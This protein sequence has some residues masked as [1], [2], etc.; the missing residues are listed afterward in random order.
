MAYRILALA[1]VLLI[2]VSGAVSQL[3]SSRVETGINHP[4]S[5]ILTS[6]NST[7]TVEF[8]L[9]N[10]VAQEKELRINL[11]GVNAVFWSNNQSGMYYTLPGNTEKTFQIAVSP[12][13][14]GE[15]NLTVVTY[16]RDLGTENVDR[17]PVA[18][19]ESF[20]ASVDL[21]G[22]GLLQLLLVSMF[23]TIFYSRKL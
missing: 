19:R 18:A 5:T 22:A 2:L 16:N 12:L 13:E 17:F 10:K 8:H 7:R 1:A 9:E 14:S 21:P 20:P 3:S 23:A 11:T 4:Y 15:K 6:V